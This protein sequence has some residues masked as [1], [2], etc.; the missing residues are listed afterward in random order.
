MNKSRFGLPL[1]TATVF[2]LSGCA[3]GGGGGGGEEGNPPRENDHTRTAELYLTQA[4]TLGAAERYQ[5][6]LAAAFNSIMD[7]STNA[8]GYFQAARAQLGLGD[9]VAADTLFGA[10]LELY[11]GYD[12][13]VRVQRESTWIEL[14]NQ[15]I[16]PL[17][18]GD[19]EEGARLLEAAEMIF[20]ARRPE[21]LINLG[22]TYTNLGRTQDAVDAYGN[23][24][25]IIR[26]PR[27]AEVDSTTAADWASRELS[28]TFNRAQ[29]LSE[30]ERYDEAATEYERYLESYPGDVGA[31]SSLATTLAQSGMADS[32]QAIYDNLLAGTGLGMREYFNIGVGLYGAA[33][34]MEEPEEAKTIFER[35]AEAFRQVAEVA[36]EN[37][38]ALF[39]LAQS[40]VDAENWEELIPVARAL[41]ELDGQN[42]DSYTILAQ[43]LVG[44]DQTQEAVQVLEA[45]EALAF[46]LEG[47]TL[48]PQARGGASLVGTFVNNTLDAGTTVTIRVHFN[49]ED[50]AEVG[51]SDIR[52]T[53]PEQGGAEPFRATLDSDESVM[54]YYFE[55]LSP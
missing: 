3:S 30:A 48:Q 42:P 31:L 40:L 53:A 13:D 45:R 51:A 2:V 22:V 5:D 6:A 21:A 4:Q 10:A 55:V 27:M 26:G 11:P 54:G 1:V 14:F 41:L 25:E 19:S 12:Q 49:G 38:D 8:L 15:A 33:S 16:I 35:A 44:T 20:P 39:N 32:A 7:D 24:L 52:V 37:R 36:P 28:V 50:G 47:S 18:A 34:D 29:L 23:A 17:D 9:Y 43:G 46:R